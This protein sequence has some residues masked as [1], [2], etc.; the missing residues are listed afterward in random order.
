MAKEVITKGLGLG[1]VTIPSDPE[2]IPKQSAQD[3]LGWIDTDGQ[4]EL[5]KGRTIVGA[6][7]TSTLICSR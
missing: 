4:I 1:V 7:E 5:T 6:T 2:L 3:A